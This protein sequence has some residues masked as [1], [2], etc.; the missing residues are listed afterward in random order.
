MIF[1]TEAAQNK[2]EDII[3][4]LNFVQHKALPAIIKN[5]FGDLESKEIT[6]VKTEKFPY[7]TIRVIQLTD[8][9]GSSIRLFLKRITIPNKD[10][11]FIQQALRLETKHLQNLNKKMKGE[12]VEHFYTSLEHQT[13]VTRECTG[14]ALETLVNAYG[15]W[16]YNSPRRSVLRHTLPVQCGNWLKRYH[17]TTTQQNRD[18][19]PWYNYLSGEMFWRVRHLK[20]LLPDHSTLLQST[21]ESFNSDL[22][23]LDPNGSI[24][25][26][27]GDFAPHN[28]FYNQQNICIIDF[29]G[30]RTGHPI[31]DLINF[32][33]S[34]ASRAESPFYPSSRIK[35][36]CYKFISAYGTILG[37]EKRLVSLLLRLQT[38][39]RLLVLSNNNPS[40]VAGKIAAKRAINWHLEYLKNSQSGQK[41]KVDA[42][43]WPFLYFDTI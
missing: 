35:V 19:T 21:F 5:K 29:F 22:K 11:Q 8:R 6:V 38:V 7:S 26:Y 16:W 17:E 23:L 24:C 15:F 25:L 32:V 1:R 10:P 42:G 30:A 36:F 13:I 18:L 20:D 14:T 4:D 3:A 12:T 33:A 27:H 41:N 43:P 28:I 40:G 2:T 9:Q 37:D 34:I 31:I 39:K